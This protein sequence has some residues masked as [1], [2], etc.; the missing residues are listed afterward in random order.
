MPR[1]VS[2]LLTR[3]GTVSLHF[4]IRIIFPFCYSQYAD[5]RLKLLEDKLKAL[6]EKQGS[7]AVTAVLSLVRNALQKPE[8]LYDP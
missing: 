5:D 6:E 8:T 2:L 4:F 1:G 3:S 7:D